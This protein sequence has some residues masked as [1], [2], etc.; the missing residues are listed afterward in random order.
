MLTKNDG[1][2]I[3]SLISIIK[4]GEKH[5]A[6]CPYIILNETLAPKVELII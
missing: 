1:F 5:L 4:M 3:Y 6:M 2:Y